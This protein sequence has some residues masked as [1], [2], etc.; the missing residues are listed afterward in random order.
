M[1]KILII[2]M[3]LF[4]ANNLFASNLTPST[5]E[6]KLWKVTVTY[7]ITVKYY[8]TD[9]ISKSDYLGTVDKGLRTE[10]F[11]IYESTANKAEERAKEKCD[12]VCNT[13][14]RG[15]PQGLSS[16]KG[17]IAYGFLYRTIETARAVEAE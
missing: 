13:S 16:Y 11:S 12:Q 14:L 2:L 10:E 7:R 4:F 1:K 5:Q 9:Y 15:E 6:K 17:K 8:E 3:S